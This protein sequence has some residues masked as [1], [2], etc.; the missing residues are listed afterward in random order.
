MIHRREFLAARRRADTEVL[1][2]AGT[3][4]AFTG[5]TDCNDHTRIWDTLD[6]IRAKLTTWS[7]S[8]AVARAAP[9]ASPPA[10]PIIAR[11][12]KWSSNRTGRGKAAPPRSSA[13]TGCLRRCRSASSCSPAPASRPTS[14]TRPKTRHSGVALHRAEARRRRRL[15]AVISRLFHR[16][17]SSTSSLRRRWGRCTICSKL[18]AKPEAELNQ[19]SCRRRQNPRI[20]LSKL[21]FKGNRR[22]NEPMACDLEQIVRLPAATIESGYATSGR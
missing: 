9:N 4:I 13:T 7:S 19:R 15:G 6:K 8:M 10:G 14:P 17:G 18:H 1:A 20:F 16:R 22:R 3:R 21:S 2:P 12:P 5:G 11:L